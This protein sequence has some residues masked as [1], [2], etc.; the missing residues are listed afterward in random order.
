L[1]LVLRTLLDRCP[2]ISKSIVGLLLADIKPKE[3]STSQDQCLASIRSRI[4]IQTIAAVLLTF[5]LN[6]H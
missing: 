4:I 6:A 2:L 1:P 3:V 5:L